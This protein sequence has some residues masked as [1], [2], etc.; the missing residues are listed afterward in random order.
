MKIGVFATF[1]SPLATP[2]MIRDFGRRAEGMGLELDLDGRARRAVRQEH[3]R[4]SRVQGRPHPGASRA[5]GC[6]TSSLPSAFWPP[7]RPS[8]RLG[9]GVALVPQ[10]NPIYTAKEVC[11][12]DWLTDGRIDF[13]H[14]RRLEQGGGRGLRL[15]LGGSRRALRRVPRGHATAVDRAGR[16][17]R[18]QMGEVRDHAGWIPSRSRSRTCRSSSAA[19]PKPPS[20][21]PCASAPAGTASTVDPAATK[22]MLAKLDAAFA[23]AGRKRGATSRSSSLRRCRCRLTRCRNMPSSAWIG[24][25]STSEASGPNEWINDWP[26]SR[27]WPGSPP[28][29][30]PTMLEVPDQKR[31]YSVFFGA[32]SVIQEA[33]SGPGAVPATRCQIFSRRDEQ[34]KALWIAWQTTPKR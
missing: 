7:R 13:R 17:L 21:A 3:L 16:R 18:G 26:R 6:W 15:Q 12:L 11:T 23:K 10:R 27:I 25:W 28:N 9:T 22:E 4:L 33:A 8:V 31:R 14:R 24:C 5:A 32:A 2:Q 1:M 34:T 19:M 29:S 30:R 20:A